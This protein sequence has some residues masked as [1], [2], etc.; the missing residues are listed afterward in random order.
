V[1]SAFWM[2]DL[3]DTMKKA[4]PGYEIRHADPET[5]EFLP[6]IEVAAARSF[7]VEDVAPELYEGGPPVAFFEQAARQG[8]LW[9]AVARTSGQPVGFALA[10]VVDGSAHLY[11][12]DVHP[13]HGRRGLG[14][15][16]VDA[17][18]TWAREKRFSGVT[19]TTFRHLPWNAPFYRRLGFAEIPPAELTPG[20]S[21]L[22]EDEVQRGL[23]GAKRVAMRLDLRT[24]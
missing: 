18:V 11:E 13:D 2:L 5:L 3:G 14:T 20:L 7:P 1:F 22:L 16:L 12:M 10:T 19:L 4:I 6:A 9:T 21:K 23:D 15:A 17:V 24:R 8:L